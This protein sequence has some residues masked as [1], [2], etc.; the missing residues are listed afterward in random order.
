MDSEIALNIIGQALMAGRDNTPL[1]VNE[2]KDFRAFHRSLQYFHLEWLRE[3]INKICKT[4]NDKADYCYDEYIQAIKTI[5]MRN[6]NIC[7][8][9]STESNKSEMI[10]HSIPEIHIYVDGTRNWPY[11][12]IT[13]E[14]NVVIHESEK[15]LPPSQ[16]VELFSEIDSKFKERS[17][18]II[19]S[20]LKDIVPNSLK[21]YFLRGKFTK[22]MGCSM[23]SDGRCSIG[24]EIRLSATETH[25]MVY[26]YI[27]DYFWQEECRI[28]TFKNVVYSYWALSEI[29]AR[30]PKD[31]DFICQHRDDCG[32]HLTNE[33]PSQYP[34]IDR[35]EF[36][37]RKAVLMVRKEQ[38]RRNTQKTQ[39][40]NYEYIM[41]FCGL[42][43]RYSMQ[44]FL[45]MCNS[46]IIKLKNLTQI[47]KSR[48]GAYAEEVTIVFNT[49]SI[50]IFFMKNREQHWTRECLLQFPYNTNLYFLK[51]I[52][53]FVEKSKEL[54]SVFDKSW[55]IET[56]VG[57]L[58]KWNS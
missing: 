10:I 33:T 42:K 11:L 19:I 22:D 45:R 38:S 24:H 37:R 16:I 36:I 18:D 41:D 3:R 20:G 30:L 39:Q 56:T 23:Y 27:P 57:L 12:R 1:G 49:N 35:D 47:I 28:R 13:D 34:P 26:A 7:E 48:L 31:V 46:D 50:S 54:I 29:S 2:E 40:R 17:K 4:Y 5:A 44:E 51:D 25:D 21:N 6:G 8:I 58:A 43:E 15:G 53:V 9:H 55:D 32:V 14:Y 52:D